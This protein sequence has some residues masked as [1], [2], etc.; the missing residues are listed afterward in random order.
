MPP[1]ASHLDETDR[2]DRH[3]APLFKSETTAP[4]SITRMSTTVWKKVLPRLY[5]VENLAK[6][7]DG[8]YECFLA[9]LFRLV[10]FQ[11]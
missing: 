2:P 5:P 1:L 7:S 6:A 8:S 4:S 11:R 9:S 10:L 3:R